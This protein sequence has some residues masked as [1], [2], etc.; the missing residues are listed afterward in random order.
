MIEGIDVSNNQGAIDWGRVAQ[1]GKQ[2]AMLKASEG[3]DFRDGWMPNYVERARS[4]G[5]EVGY[6]H[7]AQPE[8]YT[9]ESEADWFVQCVAPYLNDGE[10][11]ALDLEVGSGDLSAWASR[12]LQRVENVMGFKPLLY[13][14]SSFIAEHNL[15]RPALAENGLWLASWGLSSIPPAPAPWEFL[16]MWQYAG[17]EGRCP[18]VNGGCDLDLF[19]GTREQFRLY[20]RQEAPTEPPAPQEPLLTLEDALRAVDDARA[21]LDDARALIERLLES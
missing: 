12:F 15:N 10:P 5:M 19:N 6:Y 18:G 1:A 8:L 16:T 4:V 3:I 11:M 17:D 7:F 14:S 9:P 20:G 21:R 13:S 2:F